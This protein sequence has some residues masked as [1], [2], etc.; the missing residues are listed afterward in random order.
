MH[1]PPKHFDKY[2]RAGAY[3][4][5]QYSAGT[6]Y[7]RHADRVA[8]WIKEKVVLDIGAGDGKITSML[9]PYCVG[10]DNEP[11]GVKL[12]QE[13]GVNVILGDA[14]NLPYRDGEFESVLMADV[15]EHFEFPEKA[16]AEARRV[17][18]QYIYITTPPKR[19]DGKLSDRYHW[20][21]WSPEELKALVEA[22]GFELIGGIL[23]IPSEKVMY[24][25]FRKVSDG[26]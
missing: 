9:G 20:I 25:R 1:I 14:Y 17:L 24:G 21:E 26:S 5:A 18:Q 16:L 12:A 11:E 23:S 19:P 8:E 13:H 15:L 4:W 6:K 22:Q 2:L 3:H 7:R 10:I